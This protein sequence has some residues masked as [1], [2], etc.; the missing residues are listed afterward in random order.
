MPKT[1]V[2]MRKGI[3]N[4]PTDVL[5]GLTLKVYKFILKNTNPSGI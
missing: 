5:R 3:L 2:I 1:P 4:E